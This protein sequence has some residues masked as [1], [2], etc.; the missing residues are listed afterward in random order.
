MSKSYKG[1]ISLLESFRLPG[2]ITSQ[3]VGFFELQLSNC[4]VF[5]CITEYTYFI[6][7]MNVLA[8]NIF[9]SFGRKS[10]HILTGLTFNYHSSRSSRSTTTTFL[11]K[12]SLLQRKAAGSRHHPQQP[13]Y[14]IASDTDNLISGCPGLQSSSR[15]TNLNSSLYYSTTKKNHSSTIS[16]WGAKK[17]RNHPKFGKQSEIF[18]MS[19]LEQEKIL[20]PLRDAVK[21][22]VSFLVRKHVGLGSG[23]G[24]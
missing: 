4:C 16:V 13:C 9:C 19:S 2:N 7:W 21:E 12:K 6:A 11:L 15:G 1:S 8:G 22:Q 3:T 10:R 14:L 24:V 5:S 17:R 18:E 23:Q 20:T